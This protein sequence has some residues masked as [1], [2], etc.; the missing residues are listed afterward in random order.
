MSTFHERHQ[1][2]LILIK[3]AD[4]LDADP[5]EPLARHIREQAM[6]WADRAVSRSLPSGAHTPDAFARATA[7]LPL[8]DGA[9]HGEYATAL[10]AAAESV[11][12]R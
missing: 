8:I 6:E 7:A 2:T 12:A 5:A 1:A 4:L 10:R 11:N 3:A 9:T